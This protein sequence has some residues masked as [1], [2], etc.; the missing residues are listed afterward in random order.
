MSDSI[1]KKMLNRIRES[2]FTEEK[3]SCVIQEKIEDDNFLNRSKIL[4]E[5][6]ESETKQTKDYVIK[7]NDVQFGNMRTSQEETLRNTVGD[8]AL[9][10][11]ALVYHAGID[12]ITLDGYIKGLNIKFQFRYNDPSGDGC[13]ITGADMQLSDANV[14]TIEKIRSAFQNWKDS[15]TKDG[16]TLKD[17]E[18]AAKRQTN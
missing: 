9:K 10:D 8:V 12:D 14:R 6:A 16:S 1:T 17:L 4:M 2:K 13:Y 11:D 3:E 7:P 15:I 18:N 5:E